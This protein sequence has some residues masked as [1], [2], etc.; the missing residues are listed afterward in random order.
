MDTQTKRFKEIS[1]FS[2]GG[3]G[4]LGTQHLLGWET[5]CYVEHGRQPQKQLSARIDDGY[6]DDSLIWDDVRTFD[7]YA[8]RGIA[9]VVSAG[10]PCQPYSSAGEQHGAEDYRNLWP[11]TIRIIRETEV[12]WVLLENVTALL[13]FS[14]F[15]RILADLAE[16]GFD[17]R[18]ECVSAFDVGAPHL[19]DRLW[20]VS[21]RSGGR[22][23]ITPY[24]KKVQA[25]RWGRHSDRVSWWKTEPKMDRVANGLARG[26]VQ[27]LFSLGEGQVPAVVAEA[28]KRMTKEIK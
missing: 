17:T 22:R 1:L 24:V 5:V 9:N 7:G 21:N 26:M 8:W 25:K 2:G 20:I 15:G 13:Q 14:Y 19:R 23:E 18:Y 11:D 16:S 12:P 6:L 27:Q 4:L 10:F 28:W 3:G